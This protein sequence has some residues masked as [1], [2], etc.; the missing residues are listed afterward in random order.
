MLFHSVLSLSV[1][2][3]IPNRSKYFSIMSTH[4]QLVLLLLEQK[5]RDSRFLGRE[6]HARKDLLFCVEHLKV[7]YKYYIE[8]KQI[9]GPGTNYA[10]CLR[11]KKFHSNC[12]FAF[13]L[14]LWA[15]A[16]SCIKTSCSWNFSSLENCVL[17]KF[18]VNAQDVIFSLWWSCWKNIWYWDLC[19]TSKYNLDIFILLLFLY[20]KSLIDFGRRSQYGKR[21]I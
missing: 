11:W 12:L 3:M 21:V 10:L 7:L 4:R 6:T 20:L 17:I 19:R 2:A 13:G 8:C 14:P 9:V 1:N 15:V 16:E 5:R 18:G